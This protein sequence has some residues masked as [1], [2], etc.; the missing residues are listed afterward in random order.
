MAV[1]IRAE[2]RSVGNASSATRATAGTSLARSYRT[3]AV[4]IVIDA[5]LRVRMRPTRQASQP[6]VRAGVT[7]P[8]NTPAEYVSSESHTLTR[9]PRARRISR[10]RTATMPMLMRYT[11]S[12]PTTNPARTSV[13]S[14]AAVV[15]VFHSPVTTLILRLWHIDQT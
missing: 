5:S 10:H 6:S 2:G 15:S 3:E 13:R 1:T 7:L 4:A 11:P 12:A 9:T 8:A 14:F